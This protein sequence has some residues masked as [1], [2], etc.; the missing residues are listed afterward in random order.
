[1]TMTLVCVGLWLGLNVAFVA[2]RAYVT[3]PSRTAS[4]RVHYIHMRRT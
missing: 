3:V 4:A 1:M 2:R